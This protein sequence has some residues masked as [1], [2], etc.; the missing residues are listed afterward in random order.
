MAD[1]SP[2][3][4]E[5]AAITARLDRLP[6]SRHVWRLVVLLSL[7]G[8][9]EMYDLLLTAY[10][11]PGL[12]RAEIF[13]AGEEGLADQAAFAAVT[14]AG[15]FVGTLVFA[16]VADRFGRRAVFTYSLLWYAAANVVMAL[17]STRDGVNLWRF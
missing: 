8:C 15:L 4:R 1:P 6:A 7:G 12:V 11:S 10:V 17:L 9:F 14:F 13:R 2:S 5:A 16:P 3:S